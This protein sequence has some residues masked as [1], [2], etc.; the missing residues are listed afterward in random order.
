MVSTVLFDYTKA[1]VMLFGGIII[2]FFSTLGWYFGI[3][4]I[5]GGGVTFS[6]GY[7]A[8]LWLISTMS[9]LFG[10]LAFIPF[11][12][13]LLQ[14]IPNMAMVIANVSFTQFSLA[15]RFTLG[16]ILGGAVLDLGPLL[17]GKHFSEAD[18]LTKIVMGL[19]SFMFVLMAF[20]I[21]V[22]KISIILGNIFPGYSIIT[23]GIF[24]IMVPLSIISTGIIDFAAFGITWWRVLATSTDEGVT[25]KLTSN[26]KSIIRATF[27][28]GIFGINILPLL[29]AI[30]GLVLG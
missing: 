13:P 19:V 12:G 22:Y 21:V 2:L 25:A 16:A 5:V 9:P 7:S 26:M 18:G 20:L 8:F 6:L 1:S 28:L 3:P 23:T 27:I 30:P 14:Q 24:R 15:E 4:G 10:L 29:S 11:L 17:F